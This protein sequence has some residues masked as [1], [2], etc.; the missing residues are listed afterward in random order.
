MVLMRESYRKKYL[1]QIKDMN[2]QDAIKH[3]DKLIFNIDMI[4]RWNEIDEIAYAVLCDIRR[5]LQ[6]GIK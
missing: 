5:N 3:I 4:D 6:K 1:E 2:I